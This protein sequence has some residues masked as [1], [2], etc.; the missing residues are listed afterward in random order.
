[1]IISMKSVRE[2]VA[3]FLRVIRV[4]GGKTQSEMSVKLGVSLS[5]YNAIEQAK[6]DFKVSL[7]DKMQE[8]LS[9]DAAEILTYM[10]DVPTLKDF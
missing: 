7:L 2:R 6:Q 1:M 3:E 9:V 8:A 5:T 4:L 10:K